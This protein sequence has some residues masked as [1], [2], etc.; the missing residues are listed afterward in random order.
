MILK[1]RRMNGTNAIECIK[2]DRIFTIPEK[3]QKETALLNI[4]FQKD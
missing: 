1:N 2:K 4:N 3:K